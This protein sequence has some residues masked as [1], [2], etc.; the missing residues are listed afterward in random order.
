MVCLSGGFGVVCHGWTFCI[1]AVVVVDDDDVGSD[2]GL[3][4][5]LIWDFDLM[6][7]P[8]GEQWRCWYSC[9]PDL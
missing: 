4:T 8:C 7:I 9:C 1:V 2:D 6:A 3:R 5:L